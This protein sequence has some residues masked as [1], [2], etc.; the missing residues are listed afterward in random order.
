MIHAAALLALAVLT[1]STSAQADFS[2][3]AEPI[4]LATLESP[5][6]DILAA[7]ADPA[8]TGL[9][10]LSREPRL[11]LLSWDGQIHP[12]THLATAKGDYGRPTALHASPHHLLVTRRAPPSLAILDRDLKLQEHLPSQM[13]RPFGLQLLGRR[14]FVVGEPVIPPP[15]ET[16]QWRNATWRRKHLR[17]DCGIFTVDLDSPKLEQEPALCAPDMNTPLRRALPGGAMVASLDGQRLFAVLEGRPTLAI[18]TATGKLVREVTTLENGERLPEFTE[19]DLRAQ[20]TSPKAAMALRDR[21]PWF[22]G[23]LR[24]EPE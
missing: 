23:L 1:P 6:S 16:P 3:H 14:L 10:V 7:T 9:V 12:L 21:L 22:V 5:E 15:G 4:P 11:S 20:Y 17:Q 13:Q 18:F 2:F 8:G 24:F 19:A